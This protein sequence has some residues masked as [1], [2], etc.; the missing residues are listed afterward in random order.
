MYNI[1]SSIVSDVYKSYMEYELNVM[2]K[3]SRYYMRILC[4]HK[5]Q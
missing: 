1:D 5:R 4:T 2:S 3:I